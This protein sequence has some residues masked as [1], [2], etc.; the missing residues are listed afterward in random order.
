MSPLQ[1]HIYEWVR[2]HRVHHKF[3]DTDADPYNAKRGF[4]FAHMGWLIVRK[5]PDVINK[6]KLVDVSDLDD[7]PFVVWQRRYKIDVSAFNFSNYMCN[8]SVIFS[9]AGS[10]FWRLSFVSDFPHCCHGISGT[11][12]SC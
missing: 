12:A 8:V 9:V 5:H 4:F 7:D 2:D 11:R 6:G 10:T 1:G 3:V